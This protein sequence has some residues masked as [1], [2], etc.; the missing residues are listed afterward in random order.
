MMMVMTLAPKS[1]L[2]VIQCRF[3]WCTAGW[4]WVGWWERGRRGEGSTED[5]DDENLLV[6]GEGNFTKALRRPS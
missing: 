3:G 5:H 6:L 1:W 4:Y 2:F